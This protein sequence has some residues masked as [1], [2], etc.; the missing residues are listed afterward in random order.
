VLSI[1]IDCESKL[2]T[3]V[4]IPASVRVVDGF[5][6]FGALQVVGFA[7]REGVPGLR[8]ATSN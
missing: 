5:C 7:N 4:E 1:T 6:G 8:F 3:E 2:A